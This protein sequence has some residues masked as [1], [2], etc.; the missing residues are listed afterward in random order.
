MRLPVNC[1]FTNLPENIPTFLA[2]LRQQ[3][4]DCAI[5]DRRKI[6]WSPNSGDAGDTPSE[7]AAP[8]PQ[9]VTLNLDGEQNAFVQVHTRFFACG[10]SIR[11]SYSLR[12]VPERGIDAVP[13]LG[14]LTLDGPA[15]RFNAGIART[16]PG[17]QLGCKAQAIE[18]AKLSAYEAR[19]V[20]GTFTDGKVM[21]S[22]TQMIEQLL[23][24]MTVFSVDHVALNAV[25]KLPAAAAAPAAPAP[26]ATPAQQAGTAGLNP[27]V[28]ARNAEVEARNK[29][30]RDQFQRQQ[31]A[32]AAAQAQYE[33]EVQAADSAKARY[34]TQVRDY[35]QKLGSTGVAPH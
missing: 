12:G 17:H 13:F 6:A 35:Q 24:R 7:I 31:A 9:L 20:S 19:L 15:Q 10:D 29:A 11:L 26:Q 14:T 22:R 32:Y 21:W 27:D 34:E 16:T 5:F 2:G 3:C 33:A 30:A 25:Q 23:G 1:H 4:S 18:V 28:L 8:L